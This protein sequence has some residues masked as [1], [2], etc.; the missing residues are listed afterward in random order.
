MWLTVHTSCQRPWNGEFRRTYWF[1]KVSLFI[2]SLVFPDAVSSLS[3]ITFYFRP[4]FALYLGA[5]IFF[6][7]F[8]PESA[9]PPSPGFSP[10]RNTNFPS[11]P[12]RPETRGGGVFQKSHL[13]CFFGWGGGGGSRSRM[14]G[15]KSL[16]TFRIYVLITLFSFRKWLNGV[17]RQSK[18]ISFHYF[19]FRRP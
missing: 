8:P 7:N 18:Y 6:F 10:P 19:L 14:R 12:R 5:S 11:S 15:R 9:T 16:K 4:R 13:R 1:L 3:E 2:S 17:I